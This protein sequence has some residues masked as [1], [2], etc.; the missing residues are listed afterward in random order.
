MTGLLGHAVPAPQAQAQSSASAPRSFAPGVQTIELS[1]LTSILDLNGAWRFQAGDNPAFAKPAFDDSTWP[2]IAPGQPFRTAGIPAIKADYIWARTRL[3]LPA[4][5]GPLSLVVYSRAGQQYEIFANGVSL[6]ASPGMAAHRR[7]YNPLFAVALPQTADIVLAIRFYSG[8]TAHYFPLTRVTLGSNAVMSTAV[9]LNNLRAFNNSTLADCLAIG[10]YLLV[11]LVALIL[12]VARRDDREYLWLAVFSIDFALY[13]SVAAAAHAGWLAENS[14]NV[15][16]QDFVGWAAM[17]LNLEFV[18]HFAHTRRRWPVRLIQAI[19]VFPSF[20]AVYAAPIYFAVLFIGFICWLA[21]AMVCLAA[22][23]R[24]GQ[25]GAA[26]LLIAFIPYCLIQFAWA[27]A[28]AFPSVVPWSDYFHFGAVAVNGETLA[29]VVFVLGIVAVVLYRFIRVT[30]DE[31]HAA[32]ELEAARSVQQILIPDR[33][34]PL[35]GFTVESIYQPAQQVGGDFFQVLPALDGSLLLVVGD[36]AGK[37]LPAAMM[38]AALVGAIR[39]IVRFTLQ[40]AEI[41][42]ELNERLV[43]RAGQ[44]FSTCLAAHIAQDGTTTIANAG[45][46]PPYLDGQEIDL[47]GALPLGVAAGVRYETR[48]FHL[49]AGSRLTFYSDG[50]IEAQNPAGELFGFERARELSTRSAAEIAD[51]ARAF[52]QQDDITVVAISRVAVLH[53]LPA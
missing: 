30:R 29:G 27:G 43:G 24:R 37:G 31:A 22:A 34:D 50:V 38:V 2:S 46:L 48:A 53:P 33:A 36:V 45:H 14:A 32:A 28:L 15:L 7:I 4:G 3:R 40:P 23:H 35:P 44:G 26:L 8:E 39:T 18:L 10:I 25:A 47:P 52:G 11:A 9:E 51:A 49:D 19:M 42:E 13:V 5:A 21:A 12:Y 17:M 20:L 1:A 41:L 16:M 6:A